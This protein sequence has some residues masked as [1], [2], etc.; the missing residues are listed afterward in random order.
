MAEVILHICRMP[1]HIEV[2][3][4]RFWGMDQEVIPM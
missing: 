2:E 1:Q 3:E 4:Y